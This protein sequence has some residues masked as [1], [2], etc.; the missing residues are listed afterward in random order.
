[1]T[2]G[3]DQNQDVLT[4]FIS[5]AAAQGGSLSGSSSSSRGSGS[6][7][8]SNSWFRAMAQ[9][10]GDALDNQAAKIEGL[11]QEIPA[12]SDKPSSMVA[13]TTESL[14]MGFMSQNAATSINSL[15]EAQNTLGRK[16]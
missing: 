7:Q 5:N 4:R 11:S 3:V 15:G 14:R 9:A 16:G 8:D 6:S 1:M 12:G 13:L 2:N 10:W